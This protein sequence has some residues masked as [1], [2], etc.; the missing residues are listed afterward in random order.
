VK[1]LKPLLGL[2]QYQNRP[3]RAAVT[4]LHLVCFASALLTHLRIERH[5]APGQRRRKKAAEDSTAATQEQLRKLLWDDL[6]GYLRE[7]G[8]GESVLAE[9]E[10]LRVA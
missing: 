4:H 5:G 3:A 10:R 9:L 1:D 8:H 2:G 7:K 6:M